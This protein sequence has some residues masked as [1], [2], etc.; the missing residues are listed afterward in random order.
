MEIETKVATLKLKPNSRKTPPLLEKAKSSSEWVY[1]GTGIMRH[2][3]G[4]SI[5]FFGGEEC[6]ITNIPKDMSLS[7]I[8]D[9][10]DKATKLRKRSNWT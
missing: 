1:E 6:E 3:S 9:L 2:S 5:Q 10:T 4:F 7:I 8:R